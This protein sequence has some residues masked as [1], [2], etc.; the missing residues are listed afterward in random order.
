MPDPHPM[1]PPTPCPTSWRRLR[2]LGTKNLGKFPRLPMSNRRTFPGGQDPQPHWK[3]YPGK[4]Q[5]LPRCC[6]TLKPPSVL[7][8][9]LRLTSPQDTSV[10]V[11]TSTDGA[12]ASWSSALEGHLRWFPL[13]APLPG[14]PL[15]AVCATTSGGPTS[16][17]PAEETESSEPWTTGGKNHPGSGG[18]LHN[19]SQ[20]KTTQTRISRQMDKH[21][22]AFLYNST[23]LGN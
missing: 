1:F 12:A 13:P 11:E 8:L 14:S 23:L 18:L 19:S 3:S 2:I 9:T 10:W 22:V 20:L 16:P 5:S 15:W 21:N 7:D 4:E 6:E 17:C